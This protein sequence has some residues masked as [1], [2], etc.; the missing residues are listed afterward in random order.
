[1]KEVEDLGN[2][3]FKDKAK[4]LNTR[5]VSTGTLWKM[6]EMFQLSIE[7]HDTKESLMIWSDRWQES[8][9][10]LTIIK[11]RKKSPIKDRNSKQI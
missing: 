11:E 8:W 2:M 3:P 9:D 6:G 5:Y 7:L 4:E 1:M 10:N